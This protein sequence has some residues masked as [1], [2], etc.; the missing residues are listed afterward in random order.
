MH[1]SS[2]ATTENPAHLGLNGRIMHTKQGYSG[3]ANVDFIFMCVLFENMLVNHIKLTNLRFGLFCLT[4]R[5]MTLATYKP[6]IGWVI[7][8]ITSSANYWE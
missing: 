4:H 5:I 6:Y 3:R 1:T 2:W 7:C 8:P